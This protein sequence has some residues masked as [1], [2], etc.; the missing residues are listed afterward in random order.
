MKNVDYL[1]V[2]GGVAGTT[3]AETLRQNDK[4]CSIAIVS[5]E[6]YRFYSR[7]MLSK[8][9]FFLEKIPFDN[10]WLKKESWYS[11]NNIE[12][13]AGVKAVKLDPAAKVVEF[14]NSEKVSYSKLLL[15]LGGSARRWPV[16]GADKE[17]IAYLRN[18]EEAKKLIAW[19]K[20]SKKAIAV[21]SGFVSFEMCEMM[22]LAGLDV[23]LV[24]REPYYWYP[25]LD[26]KS[27]AMIERDLQKA[28]VNILRNSE[29]AE[30]LGGQRIEG[31]VLKDGTGL[32]CQ[33]AVV[34]IGLES[35]LEWVKQAGIEVNRGILAN[36]YLETNLSEIY[37]AGDIAEFNDIVLNERIQLANWANAQNQGKVA[38]LNMLGKKQ[39]FKLVSFYTAQGFG[40]AIAMVGDV[41]ATPE[42]KIVE[43]GSPEL[44][45]FARIIIDEKGEI[46]GAT[47]INRSAEMGAVSKLI[48]KDFKT[49][50]H[51]QELHDAAFN[52][53]SLLAK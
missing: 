46:V 24:M 15:A 5:D 6:P 53:N 42:R 29:V 38:A 25:L 17:G 35:N 11:E 43:R 23:T 49:Q 28:G 27:G 32:E 44:N 4:N 8:P 10:I 39:V 36:E 52:L 18:L 47:F 48:E 14:D 26:E 30:V 21:G 19:V 13:L 12:F 1:I 9:N 7:I 34:G 16:P 3:A 33:L 20:T 40:I 22:K 41:R 50:G 45:S 37:A 2:G 31:V 51:E